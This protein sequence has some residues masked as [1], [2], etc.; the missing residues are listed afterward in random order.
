MVPHCNRCGSIRLVR[1]QSTF[2]DVAIASLTGREAWTC[3]RCGKRLR[4]AWK[5][6]E[7]EKLP[8]EDD[9]V[10]IEADPSLRVLD[11]PTPEKEP[12]PWRRRRNKSSGSRQT[13]NTKLSNR[14]QLTA[15]PFCL[16]S[17]S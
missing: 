15:N 6:E 14:Q 12:N 13:T 11:R 7:I 16:R 2:L 1:A 3:E 9:P 8:S 5:D 4:E 10:G 17:M